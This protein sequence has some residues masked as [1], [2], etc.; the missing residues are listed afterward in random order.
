MA[1][2]L[3]EIGKG[4]EFYHVPAVANGKGYLYL[5]KGAFASVRFDDTKGKLEIGYK[6][7]GKVERRKYMSVEKWQEANE[8]A[9]RANEQGEQSGKDLGANSPEEDTARRLWR[10]FVE[11]QE[12]QG[13]KVRSFVEVVFEAI[14]R[15]RIRDVTPLFKDVISDFIAYKEK[16]NSWRTED[17]RKIQCSRL[18]RLARYS[19]VVDGKELRLGEITPKI[20]DERVCFAVSSRRAGSEVSLQTFVHFAKL[21]KELFCWWFKNENHER[22]HGNLLVNPLELYEVP[23]VRNRRERKV[24]KAEDLR[25]LLCYFW[26]E[27]KSFLVLLLFHVFLPFRNCEALKMT[28]EDFNKEDKTVIVKSTNSKTGKFRSIPVPDVV[29]KWLDALSRFGVVRN[30]GLVF[31]K[32][33]SNFGTRKNNFN[34]A[35][36]KAFAS[37]GVPRIDNGFR[38]TIESALCVCYDEY[39]AAQW[40]GHSKAVQEEYYKTCMTRKEAKAIFNIQPPNVDGLGKTVVFDRSAE[41]SPNESS[42]EI[43]EEE[44]AL[45]A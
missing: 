41:R 15:E 43:A 2:K 33:S 10:R 37:T 42:G 30:S 17:T 6:N 40:A 35:M 23:K 29:F 4:K 12:E 8:L 31:S 24:Y 7:G 19:F 45:D 34:N 21:V 13:V 18:K 25:K 27:D 26:N 38:D 22:R 14:E 9:R 39:K 16:K 5:E 44:K 11:E 20:L 36:N 1:K 32:G 3:V 28:W